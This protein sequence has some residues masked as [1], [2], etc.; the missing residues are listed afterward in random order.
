MEEYTLKKEK[1]EEIEIDLSRLFQ[2]LKKKW[3]FIILMV[4]IG[5]AISGVTTEMLLVNK[6]ESSA[7]IYLKPDFTE[8]GTVDYNALNANSKMVNNYVLMLQGNSLLSE[9]AEEL[10]LANAATVKNAISVSNTEESE[11]IYVSARTEDPVLSRDIV[12]TTI[13]LFFEDAKDKLDIKNMMILDEPKVV[14]SAV[15]PSLKKNLLLG[16]LLGGFVSC[17]LVVLEC[18]LDKRLHEKSDVEAY[19]EIPVLAEIPWFEE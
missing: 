13:D 10:D 4:L 17:A 15:S 9:V 16:M 14:E 18:L 1:E 3:F 8:T 2:Q 11:I 19:L 12:A 6:Y 5:M 7:S